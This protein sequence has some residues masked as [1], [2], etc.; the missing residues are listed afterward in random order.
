V[1]EAVPLH[2][3][4]IFSLWC[5]ITQEDLI[6]TVDVIDIS[7][8]NL[9]Q[10]K[11]GPNFCQASLLTFCPNQE[12]QKLSEWKFTVFRVTFSTTSLTDLVL[13]KHMPNVVNKARGLSGQLKPVHAMLSFCL[14]QID[15]TFLP[16][17]SKQE[18]QRQ[19]L[20]PNSGWNLIPL[21]T[22]SFGL[23]P[24]TRNVAG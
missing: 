2:K 19:K 14:L 21:S 13:S 4:R 15:Q 23:H 11:H 12:V 7:Q 1:I 9:C 8:T 22:E 17:T 10:C 6:D 3:N 5:G 18:E 24:S 16:V 20:K